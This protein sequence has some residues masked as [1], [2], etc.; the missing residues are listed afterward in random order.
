MMK[1]LLPLLCITSLFLSGCF[2]EK[3]TQEKTIP[4]R[5]YYKDGNLKIKGN[6]LEKTG[7]K[8]GVWT[9]YFEN[10]ELEN[11]GSFNHGRREGEW[12]RYRDNGKLMV[13]S[14]YKGGFAEGE[15]KYYHENGELESIGFYKDGNRDGEWKTYKENGMFRRTEHW[16][17]GQLIKTEYPK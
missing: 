13:I 5:E 4:V 3:I 15:C 14:Y 10:G 2:Q 17:D 8:H 7:K 12:K 9:Y 1:K 6:N 11:I 16:Q